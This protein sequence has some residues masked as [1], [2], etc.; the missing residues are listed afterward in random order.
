MQGNTVAQIAAD[1]VGYSVAQDVE[2]DSIMLKL[3]PGQTN[4]LVRGY[5]WNL[6]IEID[7]LQYIVDNSST[8]LDE[9]VSSRL[10]TS[11]YTS[12]PSLPPA[13]DN[14]AITAIKAK[15]DKLNFNSNDDVKST[16]DGES[17]TVPDNADITAI[18]AKTDQLNF[19]G[20]DVKST[21]D[22]EEV[23]TDIASR[24]ASKT[25]IS[26]IST[27]QTEM[28]GKLDRM[29]PIISITPRT[30]SRRQYNG[31]TLVR[32]GV[33]Q[34]TPQGGSWVIRGYRIDNIDDFVHATVKFTRSGITN[35]AGVPYPINTPNG[36]GHFRVYVAAIS[37]LPTTENGWVDFE[38]RNDPIYE[39]EY[40]EN[41][42]PVSIFGSEDISTAYQTSRFNYI[43]FMYYRSDPTPFLNENTRIAITNLR[44]EVRLQL[45]T[46]AIIKDDVM[47]IK[48]KTNQLQ[49]GPQND[50]KATLDGEEVTT[51]IA[52]RN[53]S[54]ADISTLLPTSTY[55]APAN[56]DIETIKKHLINNREYDPLTSIDHVKDDDG[57][58]D[59][60]SYDIKGENNTPAGDGN[61][62][63][64]RIKK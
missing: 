30:G 11:G 26:S 52:S 17:I 25:D 34:T 18:K 19:V 63:Y 40:G 8:N 20:D 36:T 41:G 46:G 9:K 2:F 54:K 55:V 14:A 31:A 38:S 47:E 50:I 58:T 62:A 7:G 42:E 6:M 22:G 60:A 39:L 27:K 32:E 44:V 24:N 61:K 28:D 43:I 13:P 5:I 29:N 37:G 35:S 51:D 48:A 16:L 33:F 3:S 64:K 1:T 15:T 10:A 59:I 21:L 23:T 4:V 12:P 49:F 45:Y 57:V 56:D 53:A